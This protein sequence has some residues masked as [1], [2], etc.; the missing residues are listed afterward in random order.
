MR[1]EIVVGQRFPV[2]QES[3]AQFRGEPGDLVEQALRVTGGGGE[4]GEQAV[5]AGA[6]GGI[7]RLRDQQ[8]VG[9]TGESG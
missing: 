2:G 3:H 5:L 4:N 6:S 8:R 9:R 1:R 7:C